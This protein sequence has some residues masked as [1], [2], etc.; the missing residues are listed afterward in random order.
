VF[1]QHFV[2]YKSAACHPAVSHDPLTL[3]KQVREHSGVTH[4]NVVFEIGYY[5]VYFQA[6]GGALH[7][8]LGHHATEPEVLAGW[9][10]TRGN[11][12]GVEECQRSRDAHAGDDAENERHSFLTRSHDSS[13]RI[14]SRRR[15]SSRD[16]ASS[17]RAHT[18]FRMMTAK[19]NP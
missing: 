3:A 17:R 6:A 13:P 1:G 15:A 10:F 5:E 7:T 9:N 14:A 2:G 4:G 16:F 11:L 19:V 12:G 18:I 8:T